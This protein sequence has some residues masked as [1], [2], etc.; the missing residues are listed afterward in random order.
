V[1]A[2]EVHVVLRYLRGWHRIALGRGTA[3]NYRGAMRRAPSSRIVSPL[4]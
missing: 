2:A 1:A 4:R 3:A